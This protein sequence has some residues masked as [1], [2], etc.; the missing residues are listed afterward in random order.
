VVVSV[1]RSKAELVALASAAGVRPTRSAVGGD[2]I[3]I[4]HCRRA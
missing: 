3:R 2:R 4:S 1:R